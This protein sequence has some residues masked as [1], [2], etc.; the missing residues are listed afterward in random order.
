MLGRFI[1]LSALTAIHAVVLRDARS[2]A[3]LWFDCRATDSMNMFSVFKQYLPFQRLLAEKGEVKIMLPGPG[4]ESVPLTLDG[5]IGSGV[6]GAVFRVRTAIGEP[7]VMKVHKSR[8]K[9]E[10]VSRSAERQMQELL[11]GGAEGVMDAGKRMFVEPHEHGELNILN[12]KEGVPFYAQLWDL[13]PGENVER[14]L[15][16]LKA[17]HARIVPEDFKRIASGVLSAVYFLRERGWS[18]GDVR[19]P[20]VMYDPVSG[21]VKL[22]DYDTLG[23]ASA[24]KMD[25]D[26]KDAQDILATLL[27][28]PPKEF[29]SNPR[30][31]TK[32]LAELG[33]GQQFVGELRKAGLPFAKQGKLKHLANAVRALREEPKDRLF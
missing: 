27:G 28:L 30:T 25:E 33:I 22:V 1:I 20:N 7:R 31:T 12:S 13:A 8:G 15:A 24:K 23:V 6:Y 29:F 16:A 21:V 17:K 18:H 5:C 4:K 9:G 14:W 2:S 11:A 32:R 10:E 19:A 26:F 3:Q